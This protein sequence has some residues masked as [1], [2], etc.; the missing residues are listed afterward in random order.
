MLIFDRSLQKEVRALF[1][2]I[3]LLLTTVLLVVG[4]M[5]LLDEAASMS[6]PPKEVFIMLLISALSRSQNLVAASLFITVLL[7]LS[8]FN[9]EGEMSA[10][11]AAGVSKIRFVPPIFKMALPIALAILLISCVI[12]PW[13]ARWSLELEQQSLAKDDVGFLASGQF[14][15]SGDGA[16]VLYVQKIDEQSGEAEQVFV[17]TRVH[18]PKDGVLERVMLTSKAEFTK[19]P[20]IRRSVSLMNGQGVEFNY[21]TQETNWL[22]FSRYFLYLKDPNFTYNVQDARYKLTQDLVNVEGRDEQAELFWRLSFPLMTLVLSILAVPLSFVRPRSGKA[23]HG[24]SALILFLVYNNATSYVFNLIE[25][26]KISWE[27]GLFGLHGSVAMFVLMLLVFPVMWA[28]L[29]SV[30]RSNI[31]RQVQI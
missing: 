29:R 20:N 17:A 15:E 9:Q 11:L 1:G 21:H 28:K 18:D 25:K 30:L 12:V 27:F 5:R 26:G 16:R 31:Q 4:L 6:L 3:L 19:D 13:S 10:W 2:M 8:R 24:M 14:R 23:M 7:V 22:G